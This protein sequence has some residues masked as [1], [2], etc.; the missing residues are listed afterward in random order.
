[1]AAEMSESKLGSVAYLSC[2]KRAVKTINKGLD[3]E[4]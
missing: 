4:M 2:Y 3:E 1:M